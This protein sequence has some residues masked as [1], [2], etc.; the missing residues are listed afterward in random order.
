MK[1]STDERSTLAVEVSTCHCVIAERG[2]DG[3]LSPEV[4]VSLGLQGVRLC[5]LRGV[6]GD[7]Y[8]N[9]IP[10][11]VTKITAKRNRRGG[12]GSATFIQTT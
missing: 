8:G 7:G 9:T 5:L 1:V 12:K 2:G 4:C 3:K 11:A 6:M 10:Q